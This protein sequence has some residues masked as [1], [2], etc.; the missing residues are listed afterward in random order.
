M[1]FKIKFEVQEQ[2]KAAITDPML[3][4]FKIVKHYLQKTITVNKIP[5]YLTKFQ[6]SQSMCPE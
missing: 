1:T 6:D 3:Q 4:G 2:S 5:D